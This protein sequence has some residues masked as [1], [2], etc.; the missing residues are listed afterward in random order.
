MGHSLV[1]AEQD[2]RKHLLE[3]VSRNWLTESTVADEEVHE[4]ATVD[5]LESD[6]SDSGGLSLHGEGSFLV[7]AHKLDD[8]LVVAS[9]VDLM[10]SLGFLVEE[11]SDLSGSKLSAVVD[12][13]G[14][15]LTISGAGINL[16]GHALSQLLAEGIS[17]NFS[18]NSWHVC[19]LD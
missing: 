1:V 18:Q 9:L 17:V 6:V 11:L 15:L 12:L 8:I 4:L 19:F 10:L 3:E 16:T 13:D 7:A 14:Q 2:T 5:E